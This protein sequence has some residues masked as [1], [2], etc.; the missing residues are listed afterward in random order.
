MLITTVLYARISIQSFEKWREV[1]SN[2]SFSQFLK[3]ES[4]VREFKNS[5]ERSSESITYKRVDFQVKVSL[6]VK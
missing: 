3:L 5:F 2:L 1:Q 4:Y 6:I